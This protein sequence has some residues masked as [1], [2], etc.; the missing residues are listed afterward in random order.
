MSRYDNGDDMA[1]A[2]GT[3]QKCGGRYSVRKDA[4]LLSH[5]LREWDGSKLGG[6]CPGSGLLPQ[7]DAHH[8]R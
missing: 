4:T 7:E 8:G 5:K 1:R 3:C 6:Q 2:F